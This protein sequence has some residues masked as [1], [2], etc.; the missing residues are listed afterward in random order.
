MKYYFGDFIDEEFE[1]VLQ[2]P[3]NIDLIRS[4]NCYMNVIEENEKEK[5]FPYIE[6]GNCG[7]SQQRKFNKNYVC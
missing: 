5:L 1:L 4:Q 3:K 6:M 7:I 2:D